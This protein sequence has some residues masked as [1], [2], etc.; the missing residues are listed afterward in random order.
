MWSG[1]WGRG[2]GRG[3]GGGEDEGD[4]GVPCSRP[5]APMG[6][7]SSCSS[8][9]DAAR[10]RTADGE[11][12]EEEDARGRRTAEEVGGRGPIRTNAMGGVLVRI[13]R[14]RRRRGVWERM[15]RRRK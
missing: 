1:G 7:P 2:W 11:E 6:T 13:G 8:P 4:G 9:I 10:K 12:G 3:W 15:M 5:V 14:R